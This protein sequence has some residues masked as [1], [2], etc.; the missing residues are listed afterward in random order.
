M[1]KD[2]LLNKDLDLAELLGDFETGISDE[3]HIELLLL[4]HKGEF[5]LEPLMGVGIANYLKAPTTLITRRK[6]EKEI[7]LQLE[8]DGA[9]DVSVELDDLTVVTKVKPTEAQLQ[10]LLFTWKVAKYVKSNAIVILKF[11]PK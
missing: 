6:L 10:D 5:K 9:V 8:A 4:A 3:Q 1:A 7:K 11:S 2:I